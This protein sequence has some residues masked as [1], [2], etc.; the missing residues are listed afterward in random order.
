MNNDK[1]ELKDIILLFKFVA[2]LLLA[3]IGIGICVTF[4]PIVLVALFLIPSKA[5]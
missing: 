2:Y 3:L 5:W 1:L 4:P